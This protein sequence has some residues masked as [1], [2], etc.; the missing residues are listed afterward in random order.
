MTMNEYSV[1]EK[2]IVIEITY[3]GEVFEWDG[4][5]TEI[6]KYYIETKHERN[7]ITHPQWKNFI[8][9]YSPT[10]TKHHTLHNIKKL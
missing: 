6:T 8:R 7:P 4:V 9:A 10:W 5:V 1:G 2:V 3:T